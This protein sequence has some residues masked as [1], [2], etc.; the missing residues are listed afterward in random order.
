MNVAECLFYV[1]VALVVGGFA[2]YWSY[3]ETL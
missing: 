2:I 3:L 1:Y